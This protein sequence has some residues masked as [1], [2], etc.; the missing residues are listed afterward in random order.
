[1]YKICRKIQNKR[2]APPNTLIKKTACPNTLIQ[3][4]TAYLMP[5]LFLQVKIEVLQP[6]HATARNGFQ[7]FILDTKIHL[8]KKK[9][10]PFMWIVILVKF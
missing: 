2:I 7:I 10:T 3:Y 5:I 8:F 9:N 6:I 1:M 4:F